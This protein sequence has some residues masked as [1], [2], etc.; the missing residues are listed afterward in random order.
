MKRPVTSPAQIIDLLETIAVTLRQKSDTDYGFLREFMQTKLEADF[1]S[2]TWPFLVELSLQLPILFPDSTLSILSD[3][4]PIL[5][6]S[7]KQTACLVVHQFLCTLA[8]PTWQDGYQD[9]HIWYGSEQ[10]HAGAVDAYLTALF[11]YFGRLSGPADTSPLNCDLEDWSITFTLRTNSEA[12]NHAS[13]H[14]VSFQVQFLQEASTAPSLLGLPNGAAVI[15]ANKFIGFGRTGTQEEV[16]V[17]ASPES[18]P[19]VLVTPPLRD[20]DV[21]VV[22]GAEAMV[23]IEG[24]GRTA[25]CGEVLPSPSLEDL[26]SY[27]EQWSQ[28]TMLF[29]DA[30]ELDLEG[31]EQGLPDLQPGNVGRE[32]R[33][34]YT[35]FRSSQD[36]PHGKPFDIVYTGFWGCRTFGGN[37]S[38][39]TMI[40]WC[41]ASKAGC[42]EMRFIC[43]GEEQEKFG[44]KM[45]RFVE[46]VE[47][48]KIETAQLERVLVEL[49]MDDVGPG[50]D[51]LDVVLARLERMRL[52]STD[53]V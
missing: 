15:S 4:T 35:A 1:F 40:Q 42:G 49:R 47:A 48:K 16:Q 11:T 41:A 12:S 23:S 26:E 21:M 37:S 3:K 29:M 24:Y 45:A 10:P 51:A 38:V 52:D 53:H 5:R 14:L 50:D 6:M 46:E 30:L 32:L 39:K 9:F 25:R 7:R 28:R 27:R 20:G 44:G 17:G 34:A 2:R 33:K 36:R 8:A 22:T 19:A 31:R 13:K 43:W 18:C